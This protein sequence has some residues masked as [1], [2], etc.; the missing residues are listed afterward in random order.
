MSQYSILSTK[1]L[2]PHLHEWAQEKGYTITECSLI[3]TLSRI[4]PALSKIIHTAAENKEHRQAAIFT[5]EQAVKILAEVLPTAQPLPWDVYCI[6]GAT[7]ES[8]ERS[9]P[10]TMIAGTAAYGDILGKLIIESSYPHYHFFCGNRRKEAIPQALTDG[11]KEWTEYIIY[12]TELTPQALPVADF[13]LFYSPS[14]VDSYFKYNTLALKTV[15]IAIGDT[16]AHTLEQHTANTIITSAHTSPQS[17]LEAVHQ[18]VQKN[19]ISL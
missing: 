15:C 12:Q 16:T 19:L 5:S 3:T 9:F 1:V 2:D 6:H 13:V 17:M 10:G 7:R 8:I 11:N 14:G 4:T 18:Y